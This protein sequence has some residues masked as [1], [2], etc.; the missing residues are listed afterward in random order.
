[1]AKELNSKEEIEAFIDSIDTFLLDCDGVIWSGN[2][3]IDGVQ[4]VLDLLR[5][6]GKRLLFVT[7][8]ST[9]SRAAYLK[10]F[11]SLHINASVDEIFGSSY[12]AA[13]YIANVLNF[14]KDKKVYVIGM[15]GIRE[16]L[17]SEGIRYA[18]AE[19]DNEN[20]ADMSLMSSIH[21]DP[22]IGAV[23]LGFDLNIN[24]KKLAK[25]FTYLH[26]DDQCHF[27]ATNSDL[28]FP[29]GGTVYPGTGALLAALAAP[30]ERKPLVLGKPHQPML[31]VIVAKY[32]LNKDRTCM[33]GDRLD[34]DI[35]FG[36]KGGLK[37]LLVMT[38]VTN[39]DK[40]KRSPIQPDCYISS[41]GWLRP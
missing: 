36:K 38:G 10:K 15:S 29:A 3:V 6:K 40:L 13:Y 34:T 8:N 23:L 21:P 37:T 4:E 22:E 17:A 31:D 5:A 14:P 9:K 16:E 24:Y 2:H 32:H 12:A 26:A 20:L 1:M 35:E 11:A 25:A 39:P 28:T 18:G 33:I 27:L 7:N 30:L 19:D 41:L